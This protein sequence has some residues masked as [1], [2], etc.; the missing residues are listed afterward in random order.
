MCFSSFK[1]TDQSNSHKSAV[2][3]PYSTKS[4]NLALIL[5]SK[6][7]ELSVESSRQISVGE[8]ETKKKKLEELFLRDVA[9]FES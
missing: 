9:G 8:F 6:Q 2:G 1:S 3:F 4:A 5:I 7:K